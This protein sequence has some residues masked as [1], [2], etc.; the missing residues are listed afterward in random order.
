M[1]QSTLKSADGMKLQNGRAERGCILEHEDHAMMSRF[2]VTSWVPMPWLLDI[3][4]T[5]NTF[6]TGILAGV[7]FISTFGLGLLQPRL[8]RTSRCSSASH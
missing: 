3:A 4:R 6:G 1:R 2:D 5:L 8:K 7:L